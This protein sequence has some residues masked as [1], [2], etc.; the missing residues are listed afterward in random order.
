MRWLNNVYERANEDCFVQQGFHTDRLAFR[1]TL[2]VPE[3]LEG[4]CYLRIFLGDDQA[5]ALGARPLRVDRRE[6]ARQE[7]APAT[8]SPVR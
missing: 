7:T 8:S 5:C 3:Y 1:T 4:P 2:R 6:V